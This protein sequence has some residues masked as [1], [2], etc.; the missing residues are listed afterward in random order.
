MSLRSLFTDLLVEFTPKS[1]Q[2][3]KTYSK[4]DFLSDLLAGITVGLVALPLAMAFAIASGVPPQ[5]GLYTAIVAGFLISALGG[6]KVQI[7]GPTGAFVVVVSAIV[8]QHGIDGLYTCTFMAGIMLIVMGLGRFGTAV[9]FIPRPVVI[10]FT[11]GIAVL[12]AS[13]QI[14]DFFGLT[15]PESHGDFV[16]RMEAIVYNFHTINYPTTTLAISALAILIIFRVFIPKIPG[17]IIVL[18]LGTLIATLLNLPTETIYSQFGAIPTELPTFHIPTFRSDLFFTLLSP[19]I[20]VAMLGAIESLLSAVVAD[21]MTGSKHNS[22]VELF[23]QGVANIASPLFGGIP[24]TGAIARTATNIRSGAKTP[25]AGMIHAI[26]LLIILVAAAPLANHIPLAILAAI[27]FIVSYNM[28]EWRE[29]PQI[30]RLSKTSIVVWAI[31]FAL[32]VFADL[33]VAV[34]AGLIM[35][36]L[37][38]IRKVTNTTTLVRITDDHVKADADHSLH[39][40]PIPEGVAAYRIHG[41]F[42]FGATEKLRQIY[43]DLE[44]LPKIVM[45]R[46][47]NMNA[48]DAT[49]IHEFE[50]L[51][52]AL[53]KSGRTMIICGMRDQPKKM[54]ENAKFDQIIGKENMCESLRKAVARAS[55]LV[56]LSS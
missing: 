22:N 12:I 41:P 56:V 25:I 46:T 40:N 30:L 37:L 18:V 49:G 34:E 51:A 17:S 43:E 5:I 8:A 28:G 45:I 44:T 21:R 52:R 6:S 27:L 10:G 11:N 23:A 14:K 1:I 24:A 54:F 42:L 33:T 13:T 36:T 35:S 19:A 32:T 50:N 15:I 39:L 9:K 4:Q 16:G 48:I 20:T 2:C 47:R 55:H 3:L 31:T 29:I 26:T 38:Y 53:H 7:G